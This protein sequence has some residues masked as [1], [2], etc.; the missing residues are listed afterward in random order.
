MPWVLELAVEKDLLMP[1]ATLSPG[2]VQHQQYTILQK[3]VRAIHEK[4]KVGDGGFSFHH[5]Q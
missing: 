5:A 1:R 3:S 4:G 2:S